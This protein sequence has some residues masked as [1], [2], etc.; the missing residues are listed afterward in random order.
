MFGLW[1]GLL[2]MAIRGCRCDMS[3]PTMTRCSTQWNFQVVRNLVIVKKC[4]FKPTAKESCNCLKRQR[5]NGGQCRIRTCDLLLVRNTAAT[6]QR[7]T[8]I[9][10]VSDDSLQVATP[11]W[12]KSPRIATLRNWSGFVVGTKLGTDGTLVYM[13]E[14]PG[15]RKP[16]NDIFI[17]HAA[18]ERELAMHLPW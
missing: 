2:G 8:R 4:R 15:D 13:A 6:N 5:I 16:V 7:F 12:V 3:T 14:L 17:V 11:S 10:A 9:A 1:P 18:S